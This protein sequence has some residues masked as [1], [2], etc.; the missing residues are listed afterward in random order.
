MPS[1]HP[2]V[3]LCQLSDL[4]RVL[5]PLIEKTVKQAFANAQLSA[6]VGAMDPKAAMAY[7]GVPRTRFYELLRTDPTLKAASFTNGKRRLWPRENLDRWMEARA[8]QDQT[9]QPKVRQ[10]A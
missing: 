7:I 5:A 4:E 1:K 10:V 3:A 9:E 2:T 6:V 8:G